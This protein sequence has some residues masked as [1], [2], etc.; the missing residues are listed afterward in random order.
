[1]D[2]KLN[3]HIEPWYKNLCLP[4]ELTPW[5]QFPPGQCRR[6]SVNSFG[7]GGTNAHVIL[8]SL[9]DT[10]DAGVSQYLDAN[11]DRISTPFVFSA[12]SKQ[13]LLASLAAHATYLE[14]RPNTCPTDLAWTLRSRRSRLPLRVA[15]PASSVETLLSSLQGI[16][17]SDPDKLS[18]DQRM[19]LVA[20]GAAT[21]THVRQTRL[22]GIFT[23]QGAQWPRMGA[24]LIEASKYASN[25]LAGLDE[26][27][28]SLPIKQDRPQWTLRD[29]LLADTSKSR[30]GVAA[31]AQP[32]ST[33]VQIILVD[34][35]RLAGIQFAAVV[36]HS[37]GEIAA[38][39]AAGRLS[40]HNAIRIAY[41]RGLH[42]TTVASGPN[43]VKGAMAAV[44]T[45]FEDAT[46][47][48]YDESFKGRV[49]VG[50][51]NSPVSV[52]LS[53]DE[54]AI[55]EIIQFFEDEEK[56]VRRLKVDKG[57]H[58]HHMV[59]CS[60]P[61]LDS[62]LSLDAITKSESFTPSTDSNCTWVSSVFVESD[63][64]KMDVGPPYWVDN[65][66]SPVLFKQALERTLS[67]YGPFDGIVEVGPHPTLKG[68]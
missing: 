58:S 51:C 7:F 42:S 6:A 54:D 35:L 49:K 57:Y 25:I 32:L 16:V 2:F 66:L 13:S 61:Y 68:L 41:Y 17:S 47:I 27:L 50:A 34:C 9:D 10:V 39:Y 19:K 60:Q 11:E 40:A 8:E 45:S 3:P 38:A 1:M 48:C 43:G 62:M 37:S 65:M 52:T 36:G 24:E 33:A 14:Q 28:A 67:E 21:S 53:G 15:F 31:V 59:P 4:S 63:T 23:G 44:G 56:S 29:E 30:I 26:V 22:L 12:Q 64:D 5:P 18:L 20:S 55:D 46:E